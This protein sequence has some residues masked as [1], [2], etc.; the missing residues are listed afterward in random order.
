MN[1]VC[2]LSFLITVGMA[3]CQSGALAQTASKPFVTIADSEIQWTK[4]SAPGTM[5][6]VIYGKPLEPGLYTA[7]VK[8]SAGTNTAPH[9]HPNTENITVISGTFNIGQ[10][11]KAE[12]A[13]AIAVKAGGAVIIEANTP[14]FVFI[15]EETVT[16]ASA[17]GPAGITFINPDDD[18]TKKK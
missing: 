15:D 1:K 8:F 17:V 12:R 14:H 11:E 10:G 3:G 2:K 9:S 13:K 5:I 6:A 18:P 4:G 16:Q 7:R